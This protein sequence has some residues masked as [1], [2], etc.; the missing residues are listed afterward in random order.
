MRA[1]SA[2]QP[3][4]LTI[5]SG[6]SVQAAVNQLAPGGT[7]YLSGTF[8]E[9][10]TISTSDITVTSAPGQIATL[11]GRLII[12]D[13]AN[14][15]VISNLR[16]DGRNA[17][18]APSPTVL[19]DRAVFRNNDVTN[20]S[21]EICFILGS[22]N[23]GYVA[24]GTVIEGNRIHDCG[25]LPP[26]NR[27]HGIYLEYA[28][29]TR[30]VSNYIYDNADRGIQ[31]YPDADRTLIA[32]NVIDG[33]GE[34]IIFSGSGSLASDENTVRDNVV[35]NS[36]VRYNVEYYYAPGSATGTGNLVTRNCLWGGAQGDILGDGIA[37]AASDNIVAD[38]LYVDRQGKDF[39][40]RPE[41]PCA[42]AQP[43]RP[44]PR[45]ETTSR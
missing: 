24:E 30:I 15:V 12:W 41:S 45:V 10:V 8:T 3:A 23:R 1:A 4:S 18:N 2:S 21:T 27:D 42:H 7:L 43:L 35:A 29:D 36:A 34:G 16:L 32:N 20:A 17:A 13:G 9:D 11:R 22:L 25:K 14:D 5:S 40:L 37:F 19:G 31:L 39:R 26:Q 44:P 28:R 33:N 38:P 6:Q